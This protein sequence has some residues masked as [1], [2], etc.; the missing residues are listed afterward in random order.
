MKNLKKKFH[1]NWETIAYVGFAGAVVAIYYYTL[2]SVNEY[3]NMVIEENNKQE[4]QLMEAISRGD[5]ILPNSD[6]SYW[7]LPKAA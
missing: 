2:K 7:I 3:N 6:G 1:D 4:H 5:T